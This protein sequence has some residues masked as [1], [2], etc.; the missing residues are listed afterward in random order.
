MDAVTG[1]PGHPTPFKT[2][3]QECV[4]RSKLQRQHV[5]IEVRRYR[6]RGEAGQA[7]GGV[8]NPSEAYG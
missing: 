8:G 6:R 1:R 4:Y 3:R 2:F 5:E 7:V